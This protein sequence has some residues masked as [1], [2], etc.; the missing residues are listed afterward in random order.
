MEILSLILSP[1]FILDG[2]YSEIDKLL[3]KQRDSITRFQ[4]AKFKKI[5]RLRVLLKFFITS[6]LVCIKKRAKFVLFLC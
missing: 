6:K 3:S 1:S 4:L 5:N 2:Q